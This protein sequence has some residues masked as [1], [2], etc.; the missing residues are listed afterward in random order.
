MATYVLSDIHGHYDYFKE[1]LSQIDFKDEDHLY[2]IGDAIDRGPSSIE[3]LLEIKSM[4]NVTF[5]LGNHE[6]MMLQAIK[7]KDEQMKTKWL[8][9]GGASTLKEFEELS[10]TIQKDLIAWLYTRPIA[11][12]NITIND[13]VYLLAHASHPLY[14]IDKPLYYH[15]ANMLDRHHILWSRDFKYVMPKELAKRYSRLYQAYKGCILIFGH[16]PVYYTNYGCSNKIGLPRISRT[17]KGHLINID[18][19]CASHFPL[20]CLRLDDLKEFY[21]TLPPD[22]RVRKN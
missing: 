1:I 8:R 7:E 19:G 2:I 21:A 3:L 18:C 4:K 22:L 15:E 20:S 5:I 6:E 13:K 12:P 16:T 9:N 14:K 10:P 17:G 11:I